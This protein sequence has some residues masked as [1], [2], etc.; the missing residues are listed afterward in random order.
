MKQL[1]SGDWANAKLAKI[2]ADSWSLIQPSNILRSKAAQLV[3]RYDLRAADS[4]QLAAALAWCEDAPQG[5]S[6]CRSKTEGSGPAQRLPCQG[7][8]ISDP[9]RGCLYIRR[10]LSAHFCMLCAMLIEQAFTYSFPR[11]LEISI[12]GT[13]PHVT[14]TYD[15]GTTTM[16]TE[17]WE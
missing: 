7:N 5:R 8:M 15:S 14:I 13:M 6:D 2:I 16:L 9:S 12:G 10:R 1:S 11:Y 4:L 17:G 3:D